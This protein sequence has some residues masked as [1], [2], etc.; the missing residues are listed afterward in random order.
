VFL[1]APNTKSGARFRHQPLI[2]G[3]QLYVSVAVD[4]SP[5]L[6]PH[7]AELGAVA[8]SPRGEQQAFLHPPVM[9]HLTEQLLIRH[10]GGVV[11]A[12]VAISASM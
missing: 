3:A 4:A 7:M 10:H 5:H 6:L 12:V 1:P 11:A 2:H 9:R 8:S